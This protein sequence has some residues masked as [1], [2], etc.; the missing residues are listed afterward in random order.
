VE[1]DTAEVETRDDYEVWVFAL[2][3]EDEVELTRV[4]IYDPAVL[5]GASQTVSVDAIVPE[6]PAKYLLWPKVRNGEWGPRII[7]PLT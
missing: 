3:A 2:L 6:P 1:L 4:D 5:T 7:R